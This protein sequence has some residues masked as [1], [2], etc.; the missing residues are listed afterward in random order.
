MFLRDL[1]FHKVMAKK[2][3]KERIKVIMD[4]N[5]FLIFAAENLSFR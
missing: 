1:R 4:G 5:C 2:G 3:N